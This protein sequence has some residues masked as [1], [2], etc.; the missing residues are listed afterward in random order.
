MTR[1]AALALGLA[2][3]GTT[4]AAEAQYKSYQ[5]GFEGGYQYI[6]DDLGLDEH[7]PLL[8]LRA[9]Y[10]A[11][12]H[13]WFSARALLSFRGDITP[14]ENTVV[15]FHLTPVDVRY[16]FE[17]DSFRPFIGGATAFHFLFNAQVPSSVQW[18]LGPVLGVELKLRRDLFLGIQADTLYM[19]AF[20]G[21]NVPV[22]N[23]TT[24]ILFFF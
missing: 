21:A 7:G 22:I 12:D 10:K 13:W 15:L 3:L 11:S 19:I 20:D 1:L 2:A 14:A 23:A 9:A 18:G 5:F 17:T 24:Q 4:K 16:Y 8:G 6:E